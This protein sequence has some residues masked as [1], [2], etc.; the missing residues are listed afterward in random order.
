MNIENLCTVFAPALL[1]TAA[2]PTVEDMHKQK[3]VLCALVLIPLRDWLAVE[4]EMAERAVAETQ[5]VTAVVTP[6]SD[7]KR[8]SPFRNFFSP[9]SP[10]L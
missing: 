5:H 4:R 10:K 6:T 2:D 7:K 8:K 1:R 9:K 3:Q